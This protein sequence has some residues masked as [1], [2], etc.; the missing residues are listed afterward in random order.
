MKKRHKHG[1]RLHALALLENLRIGVGQ[2]YSSLNSVQI[3]GVLREAQARRW[4]VPKHSSATKA[5]QY[6]DMIQRHA[7]IP[8]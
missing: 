7:R 3:A 1:Y 5:R 4:Q 6:Y 8:R 2:D